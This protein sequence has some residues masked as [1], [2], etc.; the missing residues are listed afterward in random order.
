MLN[1]ACSELS[2]QVHGAN[3]SGVANNNNNSNN[4]PALVQRAE[5][6]HGRLLFVR[7]DATAAEYFFR[8]MAFK[9]KRALGGGGN[10]QLRHFAAE[11]YTWQGA[12]L[13]QRAALA[14]RRAA[15]HRLD[16]RRRQLWRPRMS[17][18]CAR[19]SHMGAQCWRTA[20]TETGTMGRAD[21]ALCAR[22][23]RRFEREL[24]AEH[25]VC[26]GRR[27][28]GQ[29]TWGQAGVTL[30]RSATEEV[31]AMASVGRSMRFTVIEGTLD[32]RICTVCGDVI[33]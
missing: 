18:Y 26:A 32:E 7:G 4:F 31:N 13:R 8:R 19:R 15:H 30:K 1:Y 29:S 14:V 24:G 9:A 21:A 6:L 12:R 28:Q 25:A 20:N 3:P 22:A 27:A 33:G 17:S 16:V 10:A 2:A 23:R 5:T 11:M